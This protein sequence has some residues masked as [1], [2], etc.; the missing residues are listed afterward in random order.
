MKFC[1]LDLA[2]NTGYAYND[3]SGAFHCG[4]W[5][6]ATDKE[7]TAFRKTRMDRRHDPRVTKLFDNIRALH[8][9]NQFDAFV[10]E[11]VQFQ[12]TTYQC[13]L[14][15][16][17]RAAL[18]TAVWRFGVSPLLE[19][20]PVAT[21]KKFAT[22][23][24]GATKAMMVKALIKSDSRFF[25]ALLAEQ[26]WYQPEIIRNRLLVDDNAVDA[27]WLWKWASKNLSRMTV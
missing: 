15:S 14:W 12:S 17:F 16:A 8:D 4:T 9:A 19:C 2:T 6:L 1:A 23:H 22:G 26:A 10:F 27:V 24:G 5:T 21:L 7:I 3:K 11:D 20:V 18:W 25:P 13:Q